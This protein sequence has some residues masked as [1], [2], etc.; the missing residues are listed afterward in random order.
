M[1]SFVVVAFFLYL[2]IKAYNRYKGAAPTKETEIS[3][4]AEIRDELRAGRPSP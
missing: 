1:I 2:V 4:L 3:L